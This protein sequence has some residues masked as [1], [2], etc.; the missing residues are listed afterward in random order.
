M[1]RRRIHRLIRQTQI[2][3]G[4]SSERI[5][6]RALYELREKFGVPIIITPSEYG[7]R[8]DRRGIDVEVKGE[9]PLLLR[10]IGIDIK[11]SKTGV[12][13]YLA[14][15]QELKEKGIRNPYSR[16]PFYFHN[17][18]YSDLLMELLQFLLEKSESHQQY[19]NRINPQDSYWV[20]P[21]FEANFR[22]FIQ[23]EIFTNPA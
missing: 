3:R 1:G 7:S 16:F 22:F 2:S 23:G 14:K 18:S 9:A 19:A 13:R 10:R 11:S 6:I 20:G 12:Q 21:E 17:Q 15:Q 5:V 4:K 8:W